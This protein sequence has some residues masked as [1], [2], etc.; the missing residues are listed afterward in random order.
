MKKTKICI[1]INVDGMISIYS[2]DP[3]VKVEVFDYCRHEFGLDN[4]E[5]KRFNKYEKKIAKEKLKLVYEQF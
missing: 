4:D 1:D 2:S 3:N 5:D